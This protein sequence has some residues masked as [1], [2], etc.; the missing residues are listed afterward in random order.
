[1]DVNDKINSVHCLLN[2]VGDNRLTAVFRPQSKFSYCTEVSRGKKNFF[3]LSYET[4]DFTTKKQTK[5][6]VDPV[7]LFGQLF[8]SDRMLTIGRTWLR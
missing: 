2:H 8:S 5:V 7:N 3:F 1:M 6:E 4:I